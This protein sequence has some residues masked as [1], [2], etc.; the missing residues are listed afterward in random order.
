[1]EGLGETWLFESVSH[2]FHACCHGLHAALEAARE[3]DIAGPEVAE[4][5]VRTHPRWMSV[6]NQ[7]EPTTGLGAKFSYATVLAMRALGYDTARL[8]SYADVVCDDQRLQVLRRKIRVE[9]DETLTE[10][11]AHLTV[12]RRDGLRLESTYDLAAPLSLEQREAR[13]REKAVKLIGMEQADAVWALLQQDGSA[14]GFGRMLGG[15][16]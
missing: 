4:M 7:A 10:M 9:P 2:K 3:L 8:D 11:Q 13:V 1:M 15:V 6:C 16:D 14:R 5:T 12:L